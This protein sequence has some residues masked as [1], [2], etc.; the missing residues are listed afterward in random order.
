MV[1]VFKSLYTEYFSVLGSSGF[2]D[3]GLFTAMVD[4]CYCTSYF[5]WVKMKVK[6]STSLSGEII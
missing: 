5:L 6:I 1:G 2:Y 3:V 4:V